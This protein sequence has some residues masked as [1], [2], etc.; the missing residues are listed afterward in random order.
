MSSLPPNAAAMDP[1]AALLRGFAVRFLTCQEW[2]VLPLVMAPHYQ[3]NVGGFL[4]EGRDEQY[5][6]AMVAQFEQFPGLCVTVHDVV[7][8]EQAIAMRFTEHG[9]SRRDDGRR[10]A[11]QGV[12]LFRIENGHLYRGWAEEDYIAR[13]RQLRS[14][15]CDHIEAPHPSPWDSRMEGANPAAEQ[16]ARDW[17]KGTALLSSSCG[18]ITAGGADPEL[19]GLIGDVTAEVDELFSAGDRVAFHVTCRGTYAGGFADVEAS[20]VGSPITVRAAGIVSVHAG[21]VRKA[22]VVADRLGLYRSLL[23]R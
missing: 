17:L 9:A 13:K 11:W 10:A 23:R 18:A 12:S 21:E 3:L 16:C 4:I 20:R 7:L 14:G 19:A 1:L 5:R 6:G 2:E 15:V 22:R 8:G